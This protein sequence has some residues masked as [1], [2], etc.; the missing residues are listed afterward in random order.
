MPSVRG[1][2]RARRRG[3]RLSQR[4]EQAEAPARALFPVV[5]SALGILVSL[6]GLVFTGAAFRSASPLPVVLPKREPRVLPWT[7]VRLDIVAP[8]APPSSSGGGGGGGGGESSQSGEPPPRGAPPRRVIVPGT[9][10]GNSPGDPNI[11][12]RRLERGAGS[13]FT[14]AEDQSPP[15]ELSRRFI[16]HSRLLERHLGSFERQVRALNAAGYTITATPEFTTARVAVRRAQ[17]RLLS[18]ARQLR[19]LPPEED[20]NERGDRTSVTARLNGPLIKARQELRAA[21]LAFD[22]LQQKIRG[23]VRGASRLRAPAPARPKGRSN[24]Q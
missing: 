1:R 18:L 16:Q 2:G 20:S 4:K 8:R 22:R 5:A 15:L 9:P 23:D 10:A 3:E 19:S 17:A 21:R 13:L 6:V 24:A 14:A 7:D 11:T 12:L